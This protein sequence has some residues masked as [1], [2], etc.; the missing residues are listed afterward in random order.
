LVFKQES[1]ALEIER[2]RKLAEIEAEKFRKLVKAIGPETLKAMAQAG[3]EMQAKLLGGLGLKS[4]MI[5]DG[6]SPINLFT[7]ANGLIAKP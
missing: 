1:D 7:T 6:N 4:V 5:T 3:P 2:A